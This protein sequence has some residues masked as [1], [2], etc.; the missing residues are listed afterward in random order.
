MSPESRIRH[1]SLKLERAKSHASDLGDAL[2]SFLQGKPYQVA[3]RHHPET[4]KLVYFVSSVQPVPDDICLMAADVIQNLVTALDHL[5][6]QLVCAGT[7]DNPPSPR[8][9]Y[10][11][12]EDDAERYEANKHR[13]LEGVTK[14][15]VDAIDAI[16][17]Y[18]GGNDALWLLHKLN[19]I[20]KHRMLLAVGSQAGGIHLGQLVAA[21]VHDAVPPEAIEELEKMTLYLN[22]EDKGFP[23]V[24]GFELLIEGVDEEPNPRQE[25]RFEV[26]IHEPGVIDGKPLLETMNEFIRAVESVVAELAPLVE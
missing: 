13:K 19:N 6:Y 21:H 20:E 17:P 1:V 2:R 25:I 4:R 18:P 5:A 16:Q 22:P 24:E 7:G 9:I 12:I 23:L 3:A 8:S 14:E 10:F 15:A 26:V 11:P